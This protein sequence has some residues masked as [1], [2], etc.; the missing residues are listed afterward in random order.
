M[1]SIR[2]RLTVSVIFIVMIIILCASVG[3]ISLSAVKMTRMADEMFQVKANKYAGDV[4]TWIKEKRGTVRSAVGAILVLDRKEQ[5]PEDLSR[6]VSAYAEGQQG[7]VDMYCA[8]EDG[9][10]VNYD[11]DNPV[12]DDYDP[13]TRDWYIQTVRAGDLIVTDPYYD[14]TLGEVVTTIAAPVIRDG[15]TIAV[16]GLDLSLNYVTDLIN[17]ISDD[18]EFGFLVDSNGEFISHENPEYNPAPGRMVQVSSVLPEIAPIITSPGSKSIVADSY[19]G[20]KSV[21]FTSKVEDSGWVFGVAANSMVVLGTLYNMVVISVIIALMAILI[22]GIVLRR[23]I[24]GMLSPMNKM[25]AFIK[26]RVVG[27]NSS[28]RYSNEVEEIQ[29]LMLEL[30][31]RFIDTIKKTRTESDGIFTRMTNTTQKLNS[32]NDNIQSI[33]ST[34]SDTG[35]HVI[36]QTESI[37]DI[38]RGCGELMESAG[39]LASRTKEMSERAN[40]VVDRVGQVVP[41]LLKDKQRA[42]DMTKESQVNLSRAIKGAEVINQITDVSKAIKDIA[43]QTNLL[44][45]N[46]SIEAARAGDSGRGFA[47]VADEINQLSNTTTTEIAKI[48]ELTETVISSVDALSSEAGKLLRFLEDV[49]MEDYEKLEGLAR[50]YSDDAEY[51]A[52]T[53][54]TLGGGA[55]D[56]DNAVRN[57]N[58]VLE[59]I[60]GTQRELSNAVQSINDNLHNMTGDSENVSGENREVLQ[61]VNMLKE[62]MSDF[63]VE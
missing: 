14:E 51:F 53:G 33:S 40:A 44:A 49:V 23:L 9:L 56:V 62:T 10:F 12:P 30:Q 13:T 4:N 8:T 17:S 2:R 21:Y 41:V 47:V 34:M 39:M 7:V 24:G 38:T 27:E 63:N 55:F 15:N 48:N 18:D 59:D 45:L 29:Y 28:M 20:E 36:S 19:K 26:E 11:T 32:I 6:V 31:T 25:T 60:S 5:L 58:D 16:V 3:I 42:V 61:S 57:M 37:E 52:E 1:Y 43:A 35:A 22:L 46:A 50:N 54:R